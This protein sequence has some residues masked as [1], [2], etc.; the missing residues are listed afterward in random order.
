MRIDRRIHRHGTDAPDQVTLQCSTSVHLEWMTPEA[1]AF[2]L[3]NK[4]SDMLMMTMDDIEAMAKRDDVIFDNTKWVHVFRPDEVEAPTY[5]GVRC[6]V[7]A[8]GSVMV[9]R[10]LVPGEESCDPGEEQEYS[11]DDVAERMMRGAEV[12]ED[13]ADQAA[14]KLYAVNRMRGLMLRG[15]F[16][17]LNRAATVRQE[18]A[19]RTLERN[20]QAMSEAN[21]E[22][23]NGVAWRAAELKS[24]NGFANADGSFDE[25]LNQKAG[26]TLRLSLSF[27]RKHVIPG[28]QDLGL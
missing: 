3:A 26:N 8:A 22:H 25:A 27:F 1:E 24:F 20:L 4:T 6:T 17:S 13:L 7:C 28:L 23:N 10:G 18:N 2:L 14:R 5:D 21:L 9:N 15:A 16:L 19:L 11:P 12:R